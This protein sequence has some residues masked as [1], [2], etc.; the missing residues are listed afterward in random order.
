MKEIWERNEGNMRKKTINKRK[1]WR[2]YISDYSNLIHI[3][4]RRIH[5]NIDFY[6]SHEQDPRIRLVDGGGG[7]DLGGDQP[8]AREG[9]A[10]SLNWRVR[11]KNSSIWL[12]SHKTIHGSGS[13]D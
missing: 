3:E 8:V 5:K 6:Q 12:M 10:S 1:K 13:D 2:K 9:I 7:V 11:S 4:I